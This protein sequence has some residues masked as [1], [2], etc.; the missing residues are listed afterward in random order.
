MFNTDVMIKNIEEL[1]SGAHDT[2]IEYRECTIMSTGYK[3]RI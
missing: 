1:L 2:K 3:A